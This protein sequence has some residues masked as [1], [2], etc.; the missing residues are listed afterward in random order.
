M[1]V[2]GWSGAVIFHSFIHSFIQEPFLVANGACV[3]SS[4]THRGDL[5]SWRVGAA[6]AAPHAT[7]VLVEGLAREAARAA[8]LGNGL[9]AEAAVLGQRDELAGAAAGH[10][11]AA[12][13][14]AVLLAQH[15]LHDIHSFVVIHSFIHSFI[16]SCVRATTE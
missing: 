11:F 14:G 9:E 5:V 7:A 12:A 1:L 4:E 15:E 13:P 16:H 8:A 10:A 6:L 3:G 2:T